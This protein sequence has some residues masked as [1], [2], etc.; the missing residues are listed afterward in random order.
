VLHVVAG[1]V[2]RVRLEAEQLG[3][4]VTV[5]V[6]PERLAELALRAGET[7]YVA[8]RRARVF[9]ADDYAI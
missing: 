6:H 2:A 9:R 7:V 1:P 8:P 3:A 4:A 5:E